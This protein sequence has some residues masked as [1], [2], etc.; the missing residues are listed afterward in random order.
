MGIGWIQEFKL[1]KWNQYIETNKKKHLVQIKTKL[2][3]ELNH[4]RHTFTYFIISPNL[5]RIHHLDF[6][7]IFHKKWWGLTWKQYKFLVIPKFPK[8]S[9]IWIALF[10]RLQPYMD[11]DLGSITKNVIALEE[12]FSIMYC[13]FQ[14]IKK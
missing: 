1:L 8:I 5:G 2:V 7:N 12:A 10:V 14:S 13:M 6:Y 4:E 3:H 11:F 9:K